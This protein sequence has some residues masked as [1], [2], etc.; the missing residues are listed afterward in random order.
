MLRTLGRGL[1]WRT[2]LNAAALGSV[3]GGVVV[4]FD[5]VAPG[6]RTPVRRSGTPD[7]IAAL[8]AFLASPGASYVVGQL[9]VAD[10]GNSIIEDHNA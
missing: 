9:I 8:I 5:Y 2:V 7:E 1:G 3:V 4:G 6:L 10:G